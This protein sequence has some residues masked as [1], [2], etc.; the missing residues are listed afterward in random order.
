MAL[1]IK[2]WPWKMKLHQSLGFL[3]S[4]N[5][6][7]YCDF[8]T[9][10]N[11]SR[12]Q[13]ESLR[14]LSWGTLKSSICYCIRKLSH[15]S[16]NCARQRAT[17]WEWKFTF[18]ICGMGNIFATYDDFFRSSKVSNGLSRSLSRTSPRQRRDA[19]CKPERSNRSNNLPHDLSN[20]LDNLLLRTWRFFERADTGE[21]K[22][23]KVLCFDQQRNV[24][25]SEFRV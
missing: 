3:T 12:F 20:L 4:T 17:R 5:S 24:A 21:K 23:L 15:S 11:N 9:W 13:A 10:Q 25:Y 7:S 18:V 14:S 22:P 2:V 6:L 1:S 16:G 19:S 8:K